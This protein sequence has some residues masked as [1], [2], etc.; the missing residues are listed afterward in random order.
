MS[1]LSRLSIIKLVISVLL[2]FLCSTCKS[3]KKTNV[4][5]TKTKVT[6]KEKDKKDKDKKD[7]KNDKKKD[8]VVVAQLS[9]EDSLTLKIGQMILV[10]IKDAKSLSNKDSIMVEISQNKIGSIILFEKNVSNTNSFQT[11]KTCVDSL[12]SKAKIPLFVSID[13]EGGQV[14]RLKEKYGFVKMPSAAYLG[15]LD[16]ADSS[17]FYYDRLAKQLKDLGINMNF[18]PSVDMAVNLK[19]PVIYK[20][21]RSY[22]KDPEMVTKHAGIAIKAHQKNGVATVIKHF[23]GHGSSNTDSHLGLTNVS[24]TWSSQEL[25]PFINLIKSNT[26]DA[27]MTAHIVNCKLDSTC[28][29]ATLSKKIIT[30]LLRDSL[31]H[32]GVVVSDDMQMYAISKNY[33]LEKAVMLS[34]NAGVDILLLGNNVVA[35][36]QVTASQL[37]TIIKK[38]VKEGKIS[39]ARISES[40]KRIIK[41]KRKIGLIE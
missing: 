3:S 29:P 28:L 22:S 35:T 20:M 5:A 31:K 14:H 1:L 4:A 21:W 26:C 34:I 40:Y 11:L 13:E 2:I 36:Q 15:K 7:N 9:E 16:N 24:K 8:V 30:G 10:G 17:A 38:L 33:G 39:P 25:L 6:E 23:P 27:V 32:G 41:L 37:I 12:Q 19:N 18:A